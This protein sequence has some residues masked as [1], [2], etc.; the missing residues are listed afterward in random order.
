MKFVLCVSPLFTAELIGLLLASIRAGL[1][2]VIPGL[3]MNVM[4]GRQIQKPIYTHP[5]P[6]NCTFMGYLKKKKA[7]NRNLAVN[8][9][10]H[11]N[12]AF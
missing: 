6:A 12:N 1:G 7:L 10:G 11:A 8:T 5:H 2:P 9:Q 4:F 3:L